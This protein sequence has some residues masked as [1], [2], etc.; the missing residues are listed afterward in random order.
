[1]EETEKLQK[2]LIQE[3]N[4]FRVSLTPKLITE[5][6]EKGEPIIL[7][8]ILQKANTLNRNGR[9]YPLDILK[10]ESKNYMELV[11]KNLATGELDHPETAVVSL[12]NVSHKVVD[13]WWQDDELHG[14]VQITKSTPAGKTLLGLIQDGVTLGI[15]S[16]GVGSVKRQGDQDIVQNDFELIAFDFVSSP[17]TPGAFMFKEGR[18]IGLTP[19]SEATQ[20]QVEKNYNQKLDYL[21]RKDFWKNL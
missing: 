14:K 3:Y 11:E 5:A 18:Q 8:G 6:I 16:R 12:Q 7:S 1:M 20:K 13:M 4:E 9:V 19:L 15:S 2:Y 17:S 21:S 10:R